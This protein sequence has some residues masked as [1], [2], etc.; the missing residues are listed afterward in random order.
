MAVFL[1]GCTTLYPPKPSETESILVEQPKDTI[2]PI[3]LE[4]S[5]APNYRL[6]TPIVWKQLHMKLEVSFDIDKHKVVG[7]AQLT[8]TPHR[9][10]NLIELNAK[11]FSFSDIELKS[12][13]ST[14]SIVGSDYS[15][16][17]KLR[18]LLNKTLT[19]D[20]TLDIEMKYEAT[21]ETLK[22]RRLI[23][24]FDHQGLYF[25]NLDESEK[26]HGQIWSQG[27]TS[28]NSAWF[29]CIDAPNQKT[30]QD[31]LITVDTPM[32]ALSNGRLVYML[33][34]R[35]GTRTFRWK[36]DLPH[37]PYLTMIGVGDF[38]IVEDNGPNNLPISYYLEKEHVKHAKLIFGKTP[39]IISFFNN[40][41]NY[42]YPWDKYAQI[43]V[44][45]FV[46]G[47]MENTSATTLM[48]SVLHDSI[49]H[50]DYNYED[51]VVHELAHQWFGDLVT[52]ESWSNTALNEGFATYGE[53]LWIEDQYDSITAFEK[54]EL[55]KTG[56]L[57]Q[58]QY[59]VH[60]LIHY[61][62]SGS[63][64]QMFDKHS[65]NKGA[66]TAHTLRK[67]LGDE[68]FFDGISTYLRENEFKAVDVD[69]LRHSFENA[70]GLD[71]RKFFDQ[72]FL[73]ENHPT[74]DL[75]YA[76]NDSL[77]SL[78][79]E[80]IQNQ[81]TAGYF[82]YSVDLPV[83][84]FYKDGSSV[85][86]VLEITKSPQEFDIPLDDVPGYYGASTARFPLIELSELKQE[87]IWLQGLN[88][89][90]LE[91]H[92]RSLNHFCDRWLKLTQ[93]TKSHVIE[94]QIQWGR[95]SPLAD[96]TLIQ[97][98]GTDSIYFDILP[99]LKTSNYPL[100]SMV[101]GYLDKHQ[102][103]SEDQL[104]DLLE[105]PSYMVK[106]AVIKASQK[107]YSKQLEA[108]IAQ[109]LPSASSQVNRETATVFSINGSPRISK[110][111]ESITKKH[112]ELLKYYATYLSRQNK[113]FIIT[114]LPFF[115]VIT[116]QNNIP[117]ESVM[118]ALYVLQ[119]GIELNQSVADVQELLTEVEKLRS[120]LKP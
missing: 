74:I 47:A 14:L 44:R 64:D 55:I 9:T 108:Q 28:S 26:G 57:A 25:I 27:E 70:S 24:R 48:N 51:Y 20:D 98:L 104:S 36:Q 81:A 52:C 105:L 65:Y 112:P 53:Y 59:T 30:T 114:K 54:L 37:A 66:L 119:E 103:I 91:T 113:T 101:I 88:S 31:L 23:D 58:S 56:Y 94:S 78:R 85:Q 115:K 110:E 77:K 33:L 12:K 39:E 80:C 13:D 2:L 102:Q 6:A 42:N 84:I 16:S 60:P 76:Y 72:W 106:A 18:L 50:N 19:K 62:Y 40:T 120:S 61:T 34:N 96:R 32:V 11:G 87:A 38:A 118:K 22:E 41:F 45:N 3:A 1:F 15:D 97:A 99:L 5:N 21:P 86:R 7:A 29:P 83:T 90:N 75:K 111:F 95:K 117:L 100:M 69:H 92:Q 82:T 8:L 35:D 17:L 107:K 4:Q 46:S 109:N 93:Q 116:A 73:E 68:I 43:A 71:L 67:H 89:R 79:I 10:S 63:D 49:Q